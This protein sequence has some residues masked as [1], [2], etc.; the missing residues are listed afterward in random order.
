MRPLFCLLVFVFSAS[1]VAFAGG[2]VGEAKPVK[3]AAKTDAVSGA[4]SPDEEWDPI[5]AKP[6]RSSK[7]AR[8]S[9]RA[10]RVEKGPVIDGLLDDEVWNLVE[11]NDDF[12]QV[13]PNTGASPTYRTEFRVLYDSENIYIGVWC[14]DDE[15]EKIL[16]REMAPDS[17]VWVDDNI[18]IVFDTFRD[19]RNGYFFRTNANGAR[20]DALI[21]S[22]ITLD[23]D[24][25]GVWQSE[26]SIDEE[27]W[28]VE[29]SISLKDLSFDP[30][31]TI[32]G[33]N[34]ERVVKRLFEEL[35]WTGIEPQYRVYAVSEAGNLTGLTGLEQGLGLEID[36]YVAA[37]WKY[38]NNPR[39]SSSQFEGG[40]DIRYR[41]TP[42][43]QLN[44]SFN[45][46]FAETEV[47]FR[48]TNLTRFPLFFPEK[49][50]FFLED[51]TIFR[52]ADLEEE[53]FLPFFSRRIGLSDDGKPVP[54]LAA[55]KLTGRTDKYN[56]GMIEAVLD[57]HDTLDVKNA[58]V[59]RISRNV[60]ERSDVGILTTI[61]DPNSDLD[62]LTAG[63][64]VNLRTSEF[65]GSER[66]VLNAFG[67]GSYTEESAGDD[68]STFGAQLYMPN[69]EYRF[70]TAFYQIEEDFDAALGFVPRRGVRGYTGR[71]DYRPRPDSDVVRQLYLSYFTEIITDL[72]DRLETA[73]HRL[74]PLGFVF[75]SADEFYTQVQYKLDAP[76]EDF[77]IRDDIFIPSGR[78]EWPEFAVLVETASKRPVMVE[79]HV[80]VG[81]FYEGTRQEYDLETTV[82]T[83]REFKITL[84]YVLNSVQLPEG[85]FDARIARVRLQLNFTPNLIWY[86]LVQY[87]NDTDTVGLN[88]RLFW[89]YRPGSR[90]FLVLT[91]NYD[92][93]NHNITLLESELTLKFNL[94]FQ[95]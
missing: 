87:D 18:R 40:G 57:D 41:L 28:K 61:G 16:A 20:E 11:S 70:K 33:F 34:I 76:E 80:R 42:G 63:V 39:D 19:S 6:S 36:P 21:V 46:D 58:F 48:K 35:R 66:L 49:R 32:W 64:D 60:F 2:N 71:F 93:N 56:I 45:T 88:S 65:L 23:K 91:Q 89:E 22:N 72:D 78:Y 68:N 15:P 1:G 73:R 5:P 92:R 7:S 10:R 38:G 4:D 51:S 79:S 69:D 90:A 29:I 54:I 14:Y 25:D 8:P 24:W 83:W 27:G 94:S 81:S 86:N 62:S 12:L 75:E 85:D 17:P 67:M 9:V 59:G 74:Y 37:R 84:G 3:A 53:T 30:N 43:L 82:N 44:A 47:D 52:F 31:S 13:T 50:S 26:G 55:G 95:F 77:E